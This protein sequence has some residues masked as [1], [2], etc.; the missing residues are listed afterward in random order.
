MARMVRHDGGANVKTSAAVALT[1]ATKLEM[2]W[3]LLGT[4]PSRMQS[5]SLA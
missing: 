5:M 3:V 4:T 1:P 2:N